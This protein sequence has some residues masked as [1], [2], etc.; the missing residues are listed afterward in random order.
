MTEHGKVHHKTIV[1]M[2]RELAGYLWAVLHPAA[3]ATR[4]CHITT[5]TP[6]R[7]VRGTDEGRHDLEVARLH[8]AVRRPC[9][10]NPR[11]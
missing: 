1:A 7:E 5:T 6:H 9:L 4:N 11:C 3:T 2:A 10:P 8:Y